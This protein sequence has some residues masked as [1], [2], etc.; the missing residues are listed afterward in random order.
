M[1]SSSTNSGGYAGSEMRTYLTSNFLAGLTSAGVPDSVLWAP[2]R[3]ISKGYNDANKNTEPDIITD[4]LWLPTEREMFNTRYAS[5]NS[6]ETTSNQPFFNYYTSGDVI[7]A[8]R[9]KYLSTGPGDT[10][11]G[12]GN[13]YWEASPDYARPSYFCNV[14]SRGDA[15]HTSAG[16][17]VGGVAPAFCVAY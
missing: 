17:G 4:K 11:Y 13:W 2:T 7:D 16:S 10:S 8:K 14:H 5:N 12:T 9:M 6:I 15:S 3:Y 1:N